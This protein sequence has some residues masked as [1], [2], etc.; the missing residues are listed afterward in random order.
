LKIVG[1]Y[2]AAGQSR[3]MGTDKLMLKLGNSYLGS[4]AL[5]AALESLIDHVL[6][7]TKKGDS[8]CWL[9]PHLSSGNWSNIVSQESAKGLSYSIKAGISEAIRMKADGAIILLA[10]QPFVTVQMLNDLVSAFR[11]DGS[12][13]F[14]GYCLNDRIR[15]PILFSSA[16]FPEF[17]KLQGDV[18]ARG[19]IRGVHKERGSLL[20][21][22]AA[23]CFWDV[24]TREA[25][26]R[27][28]EVF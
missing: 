3:R 7:I 4:V 15:P 13:Y 16:F 12:K 11:K 19:L 8:L 21:T 9:H 26:E 22:E 25:Y 14:F 18:G 28:K 20:E 1:I 24:D 17:M 5:K 6:V 10:D 27:I 23:K 2:L